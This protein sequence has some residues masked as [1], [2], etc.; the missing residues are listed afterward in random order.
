MTE[1]GDGRGGRG[2]DDGEALGR[3]VH[4]ISLEGGEGRGVR[5]GDK[6]NPLL[7][8]TSF[9]GLGSAGEIPIPCLFNIL[10][11]LCVCVCVCLYVKLCITHLA[12]KVEII[13]QICCVC[14]GDCCNYDGDR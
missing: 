9:P 12:C 1:S 7:D 14:V 4:D 6:S 10:C 3:E 5:G 2:D 11:L 8:L 13:G